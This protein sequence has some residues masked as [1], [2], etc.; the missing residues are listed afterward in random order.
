MT[1][2]PLPARRPIDVQVLTRFL[3]SLQSYSADLVQHLQSG[4]RLCHYTTLQGA[5]GIITGRDLWLTNSRYSNDN[6][7]MNY[8]HR[9]VD[10][11]L[12]ELYTETSPGDT[13]RLAWLS[14]LRTQIQTARGDRVYICCFCE[15][16]NLLSQWRGYAEDGGGVSIEFDANGFQQFTG[17]DSPHGLMRLWK[18]FYNPEQQRKIIR[19]SI[20]YPYWPV[21]NENDRIPFIVDALQFFVPTFKDAGFREERE[22]RLIFTPHRGVLPKPHY[23]TRRGMLVPYFSLRD[24]SVTGGSAETIQIPICR[25][26]VGPGPHKALNVESIGMMLSTH[27]YAGV[28]VNASPIPYRS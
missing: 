8:G 3:D 27:G 10:A 9:L 19:Q 5:I 23:R 28:E 21:A 26:E 15:D 22:R 11:V 25:V 1:A 2:D 20:D 13:A 24:L 12:E 6:E 17:P 16:G 14:K 18:V 4:Q 7:E